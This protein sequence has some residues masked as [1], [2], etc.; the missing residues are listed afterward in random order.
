MLSAGHLSA[1][2]GPRRA[3]AR[4]AA[5]PE[6]RALTPERRRAFGAGARA[7]ALGRPAETRGVRTCHLPCPHPWRDRLGV[8]SAAK[9]RQKAQRAASSSAAAPLRPRPP[10]ADPAPRSPRVP[11]APRRK[12][13]PEVVPS[14][15][16]ALAGAAG[17]PGSARVSRV[18]LA[19]R[20]PGR[21]GRDGGGEAG[22]APPREQPPSVTAAA[23]SEDE[24]PALAAR[25]FDPGRRRRRP[26][27]P[28]L[29]TLGAGAAER[30]PGSSERS[31]VGDPRRRRGRL[32]SAPSEQGTAGTRAGPAAGGAGLEGADAGVPSPRRTRGPRRAPLGSGAGVRSGSSS[33]ASLRGGV[34]RCRR[35]PMAAGLESDGFPGVVSGQAGWL[36]SR[37]ERA[38][39]GVGWGWGF[40]VGGDKG[41]KA[42]LAGRSRVL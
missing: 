20:K 31:A 4:Q 13:V 28:A 18:Y 3:N 9:A 21:R 22:C 39:L 34:S 37:E 7:P 16:A 35:W 27:G 33:V 17:G 8:V 30:R 1:V 25:V 36:G 42:A 26:R 24:P 10:R 15:R 29:R 40:G 6:D 41:R 38:F 23:R 32:V 2:R 11:G 12:S 19:R 14:S 5:S